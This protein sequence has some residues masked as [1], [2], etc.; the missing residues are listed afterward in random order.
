MRLRETERIVR[1]SMIDAGLITRARENAVAEIHPIDDIR[2][3]ASYRSA[4]VANVV[5]EFLHK[6]SADG[7]G[8]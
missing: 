2:S 8:A 3:T 4:V 5:E 7:R 6:L 1:G